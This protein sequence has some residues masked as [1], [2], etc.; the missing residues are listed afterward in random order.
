MKTTII[1][2]RLTKEERECVMVYSEFDDKWYIETSVSKLRT[3]LLRQ[4]YTEISQMTLPDG[5]WVSSEFETPYKAISIR[6]TSK[7]KREMSEE[8]RRVLSERM[9]R[10]S[11]KE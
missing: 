6:N 9:K 2:Q 11:A 3:K 1:S 8:Q 10:L 7:P 4:G 5:T